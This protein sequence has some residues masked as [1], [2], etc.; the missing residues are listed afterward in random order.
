M[1][2][3]RGRDGP[4]GRNEQGRATRWP[5]VAA[6]V[7]LPVVLSL[8]L[9]AGPWHAGAVAKDRKPGLCAVLK[10]A[11]KKKVKPC[12]RSLEV[13]DE[14]LKSRSVRLDASRVEGKTIRP[15]AVG[16]A[17]Q[18]VGKISL[19]LPTA[20]VVTVTATVSILSAASSS[21]R[22][23]VLCIIAPAGTGAAQAP[24]A[25]FGSVELPL[26]TASMYGS[27]GFEVGKGKFTARLICSLA[28]GSNLKVKGHLGA[29]YLAE[30]Y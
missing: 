11:K 17:A 4:K 5:V 12:V 1:V 6:A 16:T 10:K 29:Y 22:G 13:K 23:T 2:L 24:Q 28:E 26:L 9:A 21:S 3:T 18:E 8:L 19:K 25:M 27:R 20:G 15:K 14:S 7:A 30:R